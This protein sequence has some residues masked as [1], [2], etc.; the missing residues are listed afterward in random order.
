[1][2]VALYIRVSTKRQEHESQQPKLEKFAKDMKWT[3]VAR[4][5]TMIR[6]QGR[7]ARIQEEVRRRI[8]AR[9]RRRPVLGA[10][11]IQP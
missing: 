3:V 6:R 8:Q 4:R 5:W 7:Q 11:P 9:V 1:M 2:R 10:R